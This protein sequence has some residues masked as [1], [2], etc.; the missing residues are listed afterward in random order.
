MDTINALLKHYRNQISYTQADVA[1]ALK[2]DKSHVSKIEGG[3][4][5]LTKDAFLNYCKL[6]EFN[7]GL[8]KEFADKTFKP[9]TISTR[10][11]YVADAVLKVL[12]KLGEQQFEE[13]IKAIE[14]NTN[15]ILEK[16]NDTTDINGN[17]Q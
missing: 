8:A 4:D 9:T 2:I 6:F 7:M 3:D 14:R 5:F 15:M 10:D 17:T 16:I 12:K 1:K 11:K 13:R